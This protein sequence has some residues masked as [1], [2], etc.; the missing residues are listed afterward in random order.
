MKPNEGTPLEK[1]FPGSEPEA[2]DLLRRL[3]QMNPK[4]RATI[5]E[6]THISRSCHLDTNIYV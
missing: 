5:D 2:L 3:L 6:A 4:K 1:L